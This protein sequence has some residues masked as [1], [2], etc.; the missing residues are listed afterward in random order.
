MSGAGCA[1]YAASSGL[2]G[3]SGTAGALHELTNGVF[4]NRKIIGAHTGVY[5]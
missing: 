1:A 3:A 4:F 5:N 2:T